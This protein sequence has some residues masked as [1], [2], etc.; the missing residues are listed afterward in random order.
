MPQAKRAAFWRRLAAASFR[1]A[2]AG[3]LSNWA[4][5]EDD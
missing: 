1:K 4:E 2:S 5:A 3:Y